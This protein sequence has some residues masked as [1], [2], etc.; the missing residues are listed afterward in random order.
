ESNAEVT[1]T[2]GYDSL[3]RAIRVDTRLDGKPYVEQATFDEYGRPFQ[4]FFTAPNLPATGERN[5]YT[6]EGHLKQVRSAFPKNGQFLIYREIQAM[7]A[8]G[9]VT[10]ERGLPGLEYRQEH[11][12]DPRTGRLQRQRVV[13]A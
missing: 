12:Y 13:A 1:R 10:Q 11:S 8:R 2:L 4:R 6:A 3:G 7:N 5:V 9:Q